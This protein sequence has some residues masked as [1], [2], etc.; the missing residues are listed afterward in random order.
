MTG[1][2]QAIFVKMNNLPA[3]SSERIDRFL[4]VA[5]VYEGIGFHRQA[6]LFRLLAADPYVGLHI[7]PSDFLRAYELTMM[8]LPSY[9]L[10]LSTRTTNGRGWPE[11]QAQVMLKL[12]ATCRSQP[13][14]GLAHALYRLF[15][16]G[17]PTSCSCRCTKGYFSSFLRCS[18]KS[19]RPVRRRLDKDAE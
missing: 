5:S 17:S 6:A 9:N 13:E 7:S 1:L 8:S 3:N 14:V 12:A 4:T 19:C 11:L 10:A 15:C 2:R 18:W 16:N